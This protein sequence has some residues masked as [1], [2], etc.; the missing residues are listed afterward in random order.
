MVISF[1]WTKSGQGHDVHGLRASGG[2]TR[3][4]GLRA[5]RSKIERIE[6]QRSGEEPHSYNLVCGT[7]NVLFVSPIGAHQRVPT[8]SEALDNQ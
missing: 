6:I 4:P 2:K 8:T 1:V 3:S 5:G 7:E